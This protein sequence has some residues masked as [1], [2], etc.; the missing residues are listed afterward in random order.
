MFGMIQASHC[1]ELVFIL[2]KLSGCHA[3]VNF[4]QYGDYDETTYKPGMLANDDLLPQRVI[5]QY[6]MTLEM[7][8]ER[9]KVWYADHK[10]MTR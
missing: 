2:L 9:I 8:E 5:D 1:T 4:F 6:Q 10:G 3:L 7:W